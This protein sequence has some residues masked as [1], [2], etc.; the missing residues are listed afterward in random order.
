MQNCGEGQKLKAKQE[1]VAVRKR[2]G[3]N[4]QINR[5]ITRRTCLRRAF[6][7]KVTRF[8]ALILRTQSTMTVFSPKFN[9]SSKLT[10]QQSIKGSKE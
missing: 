8:Y 10:G 1:I 3:H 5:V 7:S 2:N 9:W 6:T 4:Q